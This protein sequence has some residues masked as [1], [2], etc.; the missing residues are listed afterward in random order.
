MN[1]PA[2]PFLSNVPQNISANSV[3][4]R[5]IE[6][7][8]FRYQAA[9]SG[10]TELD[11]TFKPT[12]ESFSIGELLKHIYDLAFITQKTF[13]GKAHYK[14]DELAA[15]SELITETIQLYNIAIARIKTLKPQDLKSCYVQPKSLPNA[16]PFWFV[17]NG[18]IADALTHIGQ[19]VSW[20]RINGNPQ[21]P[22]N[23][24]LGKKIS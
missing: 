17:I 3:L 18:H 21:P 6:G 13:G 23:V 19:L 24:F 16:Y 2:E 22:T 14:K 4:I 7:L 12:P 5:L 10:L 9:T 15:G 20:R 11:I 8:G 1:H